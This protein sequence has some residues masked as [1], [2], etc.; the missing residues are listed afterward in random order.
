MITICHKV[1]AEGNPIFLHF[2]LYFG[3]LLGMLLK[4]C[5]IWIKC[6]CFFFPDGPVILNELYSLQREGGGTCIFECVVN[7]YPAPDIWWTKDGQK[8]RSGERVQ[9][10]KAVSK[11]ISHLIAFLYS[12]D[13]LS[14]LVVGYIKHQ[15]FCCCFFMDL[16]WWYALFIAPAISNAHLI[17]GFGWFQWFMLFV[18]MFS[19]YQV[20]DWSECS[21]GHRILSVLGAERCW[22]HLC[23]RKTTHTTIK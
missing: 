5:W 23:C 20:G 16:S 3:M 21:G 1:A 14:A 7:G 11:N 18:L 15:W 17:F 2:Y 10:I 19:G 22:S 4:L 13:K 9:I 6:T 12:F 8:I